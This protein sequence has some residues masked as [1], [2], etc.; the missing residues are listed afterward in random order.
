MLTMRSIEA[1]ESGNSRNGFIRR[2]V[3]D[4]A[5]AAIAV[6]GGLA[7]GVGIVDLIKSSQF[8]ESEFHRSLEEAGLS[9]VSYD[10]AQRMIPGISEQIDEALKQAKSSEEIQAII[11][12]PVNQEAIDIYS[13][14]Q[15]INAGLSN[16]AV[17]ESFDTLGIML[18]V[19]SVVAG[20]VASMLKHRERKS[21]SSR[22]GL[23]IERVTKP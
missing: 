9:G 1:G 13:Q 6:A 15:S 17:R 23:T 8:R 16:H 20:G 18:G 14:G 4:I 3:A 2:N 7:T 19:E 11:R 10:N 22:R 5:F 12:R 21:R